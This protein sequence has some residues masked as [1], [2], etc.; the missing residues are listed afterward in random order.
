MPLRNIIGG[1]ILLTFGIVYGYLTSELPDRQISG[2]PGPSLFP[3]I[4]TGLLVSLSFLL[5][6][7][8]VIS[9]RLMKH[10]PNLETIE[11]K[12]IFLLVGMIIF[13][14]AISVVGFLIAAIPFF[15]WM[16]WLCDTRTNWSLIATSILVPLFCYVLFREVFR[17]MLPGT[18]WN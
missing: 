3:W 4:V 17:I 6:I 2:L 11:I 1:S 8:G 14:M 15:A 18:P 10:T 12:V 13:V 16:M 9:L 5:M 7:K